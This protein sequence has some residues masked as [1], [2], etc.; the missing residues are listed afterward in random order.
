MVQ[1]HFGVTDWGKVGDWTST[2]HEN[3]YYLME[4]MESNKLDK[5]KIWRDLK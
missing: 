4:M 3:I 1:A 2:K 5:S